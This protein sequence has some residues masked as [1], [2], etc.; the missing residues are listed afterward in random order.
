MSDEKDVTSFPPND[1]VSTAVG[2]IFGGKLGDESAPVTDSKE[3]QKL[4]AEAVHDQRRALRRLGPAPSDFER[5]I[6]LIYEWRVH[7]SPYSGLTD[8][9]RELLSSHHNQN[10]AQAI[11]KMISIIKE[12]RMRKIQQALDRVGLDE[13]E[14]LLGLKEER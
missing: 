1:G 14:R 3:A 8:L 4:D 9:M 11:Q 13:A 10:D 7:A 6:D 12:A 5:L 2:G